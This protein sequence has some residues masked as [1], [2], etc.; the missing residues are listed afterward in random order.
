MFAY[1]DEI[2]IVHYDKDEEKCEGKGF[3]LDFSFSEKIDS[4]RVHPKADEVFFEAVER[5]VET[6]IPDFNGNISWS[7]MRAEPP[8]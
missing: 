7:D 2:R 3:K 8:V 5:I 6:Y 4:I 1:E